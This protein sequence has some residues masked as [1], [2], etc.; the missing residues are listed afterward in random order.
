MIV[1]SCLLSYLAISV[2]NNN[3]TIKETTIDTNIKISKLYEGREKAWVE[4][5]VTEE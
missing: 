5:P 3:E 1:I 2:Y 4:A